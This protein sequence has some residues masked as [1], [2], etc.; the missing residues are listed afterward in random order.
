MACTQKDEHGPN[1]KRVMPSNHDHFS[2]KH[3]HEQS[4][5]PHQHVR[6]SDS[7]NIS[8]MILY[9]LLMSS[10]RWACNPANLCW[11][12]TNWN[13]C[14]RHPGKK[15]NIPDRSKAPPTELNQAE[16]VRL[17]AQLPRSSSPRTCGP[18]KFTMGF[19]ERT[20]SSCDP[21]RTEQGRAYSVAKGS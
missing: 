2:L 20:C 8:I 17:T 16:T 10:F 5:A 1:T 4:D 21:R 3:L 19:D 9:C 18:A 11:N 6:M 15:W 7:C 12:Q 13:L 14:P